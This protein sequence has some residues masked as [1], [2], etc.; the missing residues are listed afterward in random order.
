MNDVQKAVRSWLNSQQDWL[1]EAAD[2]L[3]Q[4]GTLDDQ[5]IHELCE[6]LKT[7]DGRK[8]TRHR[9]FKSLGGHVNSL[10]PLKL[11]SIGDV[12][13]IENLSPRKPLVF[14]EGN[15]AVVYGGNGSGKSS[16]TRIL[17]KVCS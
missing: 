11:L 7:K 3:L 14:G 16:Y 4:K 12:Q 15:L 2:R 5:D 17:K 10:S 6:I 13:G 8:V 1:Q 9:E